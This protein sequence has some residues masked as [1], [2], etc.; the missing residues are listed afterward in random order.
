MR[1]VVITIAVYILNLFQTRH[2]L[3]VIEFTSLVANKTSETSTF[4]VMRV[5]I[6]QPNGNGTVAKQMPWK[7]KVELQRGN[8]YLWI[9]PHV[10][11]GYILI[12]LYTSNITVCMLFYLSLNFSMKT[13][14]CIMSNASRQAVDD[15]KRIEV[16]G[17]CSQRF[18]EHFYIAENLK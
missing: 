5:S 1:Q 13:R 6:A 4:D 9:Q 17:V 14:K 7:S 11:A 15:C 16:R 3:W 2:D 12:Y 10:V 8:Y 18:H